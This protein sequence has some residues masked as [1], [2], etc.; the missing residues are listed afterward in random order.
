MYN[1]PIMIFLAAAL[2]CACSMAGAFP[3]KVEKPKAPLAR[4][5]KNEYVRGTDGQFTLNYQLDDGTSNN[6]EGTLVLND[7]GDDYVMIQKGSYS[8]ISPEG[9][10]VSVSYTADKDG[11]QVIKNLNP[12]KNYASTPAV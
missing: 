5:L 1:F 3:T 12:P 2:V 8:Y 6:V 11:F 10:E 9:I 4:L 7:E